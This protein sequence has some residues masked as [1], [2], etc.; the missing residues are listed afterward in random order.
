MRM[1]LWTTVFAVLMV[2]SLHAQDISGTWQGTLGASPQKLRL[3][4]KIAGW[5]RHRLLITAL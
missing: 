5:R 1:A 4:L 3:M 2:P